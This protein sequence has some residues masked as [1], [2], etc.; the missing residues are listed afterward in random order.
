M[1]LRLWRCLPPLYFLT[2]IFSKMNAKVKSETI[3]ATLPNGV[4]RQHEIHPGGS[5][6]LS[7]L[8]DDYVLTMQ[9]AL[10][11]DLTSQLIARAEQEAGVLPQMTAAEMYDYLAD[12][13]SEF[14]NWCFPFCAIVLTSSNLGY[15][16]RR[17]LHDYR[18][19]L[20]DLGTREPL[21]IERAKAALSIQ[22]SK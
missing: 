12:S 14:Y 1:T 4:S 15:L 18:R 19:T 17:I 21:D 2:L 5:K 6:K 7:A 20:N 8:V 16:H 10:R 22:T 9:H 3:T 11:Q 13:D